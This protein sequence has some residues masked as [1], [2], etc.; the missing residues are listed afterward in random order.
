MRHVLHTRL[1]FIDTCD[2]LHAVILFMWK[3]EHRVHKRKSSKKCSRE[4]D[5]R[6]R[7]ETQKVGGASKPRQTRGQIDKHIKSVASP[8]LRNIII[9]DD[10]CYFL[11]DLELH[12]IN[13][14]KN[15]DI[16]ST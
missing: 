2:I 6:T 4:R 12:S 14:F 11:F 8:H 16:T 5:T 7:G 15:R 1:S 13:F 3:N 10:L 9:F